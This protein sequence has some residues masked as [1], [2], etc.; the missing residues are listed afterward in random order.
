MTLLNGMI[1]GAGTGLVTAGLGGMAQ[2]DSGTI[3]IA[4]GLLILLGI[5]AMLKNGIYTD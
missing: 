2:G 4:G 3:T 5:S 1:F